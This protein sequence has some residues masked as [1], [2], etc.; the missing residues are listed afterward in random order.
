MSLF[1]AG[2]TDIGTRRSSNQDTLACT[3]SP[4]GDHALAV[5]A[6]GMG[7]YR[8]GEIASRVVVE[9]LMDALTPVLARTPAAQVPER[10]QTA[11]T[12]AA[13]RLE[14]TR[15]GRPE[16]DRM[17]TTVV[18]AWV[19]QQRTWLAHLGDSRG[20]LLRDGSLCQLTRDHTVAQR[21]VDDGSISP[22]EV[23]RLPFRNVL[24][25]AL[26][27]TAEPRATVTELA[28]QA[29]D[30]LLL[31]SDGLTDAL[32]EPNWLPLLGRWPV[33]DD[34]VR[35]LVDASLRNQADDNVSVVMIQYC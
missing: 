10:I 20:Y 31:C 3:V 1:A 18:L 33:L 2:L 12:L 21:M 19:Q 13:E 26:G 16:L 29:G 15:R 30:R 14:D 24:T 25:Q 35:G 6:D 4:E 27:A 34:Q 7:G 17:G 5:I 11:I 28:L 22:D 32:P 9:A 23:A 8:G